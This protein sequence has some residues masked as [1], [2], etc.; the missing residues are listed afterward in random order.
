MMKKL[1]LTLLFILP[2]S[3]LHAGETDVIN[4]IFS[5]SSGTVFNFKVTIRHADTGWDHYADA[6]EIFD[7]SG[8]LL[9]KRTLY[10][11]H[12]K[13]QPF[14]RSITD[15]KIPESVKRVMIKAHC[16]V[17]EYGGKVIVVDIR[18]KR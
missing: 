13:E 1:F 4:V 3:F 10:H 8:A 7:M 14:T 15:V 17:H 11:P 6:F 18:K 12:V 9:A 5:R 16:S 2:A